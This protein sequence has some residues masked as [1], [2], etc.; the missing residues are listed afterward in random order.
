MMYL[1]YCSE[2]SHDGMAAWWR[3]HNH[4]YTSNI[5][6]A[7]RYTK[8]Q[9]DDI[10]RDSVGEDFGIAEDEVMAMSLRRICD[11]SDGTNWQHFR[12]PAPR[13]PIGTPML[14]LH[15]P[16]TDDMIRSALRDADSKGK[17]GV[18]AAVTGLAGGEKEL[19]KIMNSTSELSIMDRGMLGLHLGE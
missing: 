4:G 3:P 15:D 9:A 13:P 10:E 17:L 2:R 14:D 8:V 1:I 5:D 16:K 7:G 11:I 12:R 18:V 6:E 19:R